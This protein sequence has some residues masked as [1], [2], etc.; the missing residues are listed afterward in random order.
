LSGV[1]VALQEAPTVGVM[2]EVVEMI[3]IGL[4]MSLT[5]YEYL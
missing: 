4:G 2:V 5:K 1:P 3:K